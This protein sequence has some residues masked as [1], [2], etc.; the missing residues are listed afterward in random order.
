M[1][2]P[3]YL[4]DLILIDSLEGETARGAARSPDSSFQRGRGVIPSPRRE[5]KS[6]TIF[7]D[8]GSLVPAGA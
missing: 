5:K 1:Y 7:S 2:M 8:A 4:Y 3:E 6:R